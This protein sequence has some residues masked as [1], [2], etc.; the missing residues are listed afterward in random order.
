MKT[1]FQY[2]RSLFGNALS[3]GEKPANRPQWFRPALEPR[4]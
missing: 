4:C 3:I 2:V 1:L